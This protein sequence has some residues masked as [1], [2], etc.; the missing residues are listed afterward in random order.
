MSTEATAHAGDDH[1]EA[2][3]G[4]GHHGPKWLAHH[5]DTPAQQIDADSHVGV[6]FGPVA[7]DVG[8]EF[9]NPGRYA[10]TARIE[11]GKLV[12]E[13]PLSAPRPSASGKTLVVATTGG[14]KPTA[15]MLDGRAPR[16][17]RSSGPGRRRG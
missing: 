15:A 7:A 12:I 5:F 11:S 14:N 2:G 8:R 1:S 17:V 6:R 16:A 4:H 10:M 9:F 13:I 3:H